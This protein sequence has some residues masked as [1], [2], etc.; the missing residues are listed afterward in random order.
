MRTLV[1]FLLAVPRLCCAQDGPP[2]PD[3]RNVYELYLALPAEALPFADALNNPA[4]R[5]Q[6][7]AVQD[8]PN[9]YL[10]LDPSQ[11]EIATDC[12]GQFVLFRDAFGHPILGSNEICCAT[13]CSSS[14]KFFRLGEDGTP[15]LIPE[16]FII[17][18]Q[19]ASTLDAETC[20][21]LYQAKFP[22][23]TRDDYPGCVISL[24]RQGTALLI[25]DGLE[26]TYLGALE[27]LPEQ[28]GFQLYD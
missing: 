5:R 2:P 3:S 25:H 13:I 10:A 21:R 15:Y 20:F 24:P 27:F 12:N 1:L 19:L 4:A 11:L 9:G 7:V 23:A 16:P 6:V 18:N 22:E 14:L 17:N 26:N 8:L 28:G